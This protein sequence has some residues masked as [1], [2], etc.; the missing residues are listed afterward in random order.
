MKST[1]C[2]D[3]EAIDAALEHLNRAGYYLTFE[4][5]LQPILEHRYDTG[6]VIQA[7]RESREATK[8]LRKTLTAD[9]K[10]RQL[11]NRRFP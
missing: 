1:L 2:M 4:R 11:D 10:Q 6:P 9:R 3:H 5:N 7:L 8:L